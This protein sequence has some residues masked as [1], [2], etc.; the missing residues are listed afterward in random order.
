MKSWKQTL[1]VLSLLPLLGTACGGKKEG[2]EGPPVDSSQGGLDAGQKFDGVR[3]YAKTKVNGCDSGSGTAVG[4]KSALMSG[5]FAGCNRE[6]SCAFNASVD[7]NAAKPDADAAFFGALCKFAL[8][9]ETPQFEY[10]TFEKWK[11]SDYFMKPSGVDA[12]GD[13]LEAKFPGDGYGLASIFFKQHGDAGHK[14]DDVVGTA[15]DLFLEHGVDIHV[16]LRGAA[17]SPNFSSGIP[18]N[19][20][21]N[22]SPIVVKA[23]EV[24]IL[25]FIWMAVLTA[26]ETAKVYSIGVTSHESFADQAA[27]LNDIN[28]APRFGSLLAGANGN[29]LKGA[30]QEWTS[31]T[32]RAVGNVVVTWDN[33][34]SKFLVE[35]WVKDADIFPLH[36]ETN[37]Y[38]LALLAAQIRMSLD[39]QFVWLA[40]TDNKNA[41]NVGKFLKNLPNS[42]KVSGEPFKLDGSDIEP[43]EVFLRAFL[44]DYVIEP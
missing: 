23:A 5:D 8:L 25:D 4:A 11:A 1:L 15:A 35:D 21:D 13:K 3:D 12:L 17:N 43:N 27:F 2:A 29:S 41:V 39:D 7:V 31:T 10:L 16:L 36:D 6:A 37:P 40:A 19:F 30:L 20:V 42:D 26:S 9:V 18:V 22:S 34:S 28:T 14:P 24:G 38:E 32:A 44:K 33:S